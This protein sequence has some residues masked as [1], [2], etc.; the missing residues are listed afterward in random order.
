[1]AIFFQLNENLPNQFKELPKTF[2]F[3]AKVE[4]W[5]PPFIAL[6]KTAAQ[7]M[8]HPTEPYSEWSGH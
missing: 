8:Q 7:W 3:F 1:M 5:K 4:V 2:N 6:F